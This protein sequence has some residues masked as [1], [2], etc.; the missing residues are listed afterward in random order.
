MVDTVGHGECERAEEE[1]AMMLGVDPQVHRGGQLH[2]HSVLERDPGGV[3]WEHA[4][5]AVGLG[6]GRLLS[7][8]IYG[9]IIKF[10]PEE[11]K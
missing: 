5:V 9:P 3:V 10:L 11:K 8:Q 2:H 7:Q 1:P 4:Q 6:R